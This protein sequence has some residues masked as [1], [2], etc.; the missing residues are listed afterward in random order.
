MFARKIFI[1]ALLVAILPAIAITIPTSKAHAANGRKAAFVAGLVAG[2]VGAAALYSAS[3]HRW[4]RVRNHYHRG[5][6]RG[7]HIH[8]GI[9]HCHGR[10]GPSY[11][12]S[13]PVHYG[14]P[15]P[16]TRAWYRYCHSK[17]R[18]FNPRTGYFTTYSGH[19]RF[20]R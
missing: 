6:W 15:R 17:Y 20:C 14:R 9:R 7:C 4:S 3:K 1:Y 10:K 16:W 8:N 5:H 2:A 18:S 12:R 19:K 11:R 13:S